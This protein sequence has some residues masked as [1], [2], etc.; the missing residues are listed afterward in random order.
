[1]AITVRAGYEISYDCPQ[2]TPMIVALSVHPSRRRDLLT[3]DRFH[4]HPPAPA[5]EYCDGFGNTCHVIHAPQGLITIS[6]D[7]L[8]QDSGS[9]TSLRPRRRKARSRCFPWRRLSI[10]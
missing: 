7:F 10:F 2:P 5:T 9:L 4:V 1:M 8:V 6:A 3:P